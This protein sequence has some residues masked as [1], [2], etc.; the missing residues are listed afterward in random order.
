MKETRRWDDSSFTVLL[1]NTMLPRLLDRLMDIIH[2]HVGENM[3]ILDMHEI[4]YLYTH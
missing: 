3:G 2:L 1:L 4:D